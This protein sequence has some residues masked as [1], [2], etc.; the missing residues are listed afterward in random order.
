[1]WKLTKTLLREKTHTVKYFSINCSFLAQVNIECSKNLKHRNSST[2]LNEGVFNSKTLL[3]KHL[4]ENI[5]Y[6]EPEGSRSGLLVVN[7]PY[8]LA[9][10]PS[11]TDKISLS[12]ALPE[13]ADNLGVSKISV[14]KSCGR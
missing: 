12:C 1:M 11:E 3:A 13:L 4:K 10:L 5:L 7:K 6:Y 8:G 2:Y 14:I 9:L